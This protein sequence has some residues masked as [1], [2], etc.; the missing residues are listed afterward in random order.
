MFHWM[1]VLGATAALVIA[2]SA[3]AQYYGGRGGDYDY[4]WARVVSVEP[5]LATERGRRVC[6]DQPVSYYVP[7]RTYPTYRRDASGA[8]VGALIGGVVGNQIGS[9]SG[10]DAA[11]VAGAIAGA[12]IG[13]DRGDRYDDRGYYRESGYNRVGYERVCERRSRGWNRD[14]VLGYDVAYRLDGRIYHT[15]TDSHPGRRVRVAIT[16]Y[17]D[18]RRYRRY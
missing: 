2:G 13:S 9:G 6:W 16:D 3:N 4:V 10:R 1:K 7:G 15:R 18:R 14:R 17:D 8:L 12:A 11:T 5:I